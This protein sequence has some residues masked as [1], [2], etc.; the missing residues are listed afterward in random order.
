MPAQRLRRTFDSNCIAQ[1][2]QGFDCPLPLACLLSWVPLIV[3]RLL[4]TGPQ[5]EEMVDDHEY[6]V[7]DGERRLLLADAHF[8]TSKGASEEGGRF[9]GAPSTL[10]QDPVEVAIPLTRFATVPFPGTLMVLRTDVSLRCSACGV[11]K[12]AHIRTNLS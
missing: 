5:S 7:G 12:A 4:I 6:V 3:P 9:P 2:F 11:P 8:E 10:H 1:A